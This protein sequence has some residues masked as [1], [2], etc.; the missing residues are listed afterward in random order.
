MRE[1]GRSD[2]ALSSLIFAP[3]VALD[4][5]QFASRPTVR[6]AMRIGPFRRWGI[7]PAGFSLFGTASE[8]RIRSGGPDG[9]SFILRP[10]SWRVLHPR[11][12]GTHWRHRAHLHREHRMDTSEARCRWLGVVASLILLAGCNRN[13][14]PFGTS[15]YPPNS[16][17]AAPPPANPYAAPPYGAAPYAAPP[18]AAAPGALPAVPALPPAGGAAAA[19]PASMQMPDWSNPGTM[20]QQQARATYHDPYADTTAAPEIVGGRP[21]EF[22]KPAAEPVRSR[23]FRNTRFPF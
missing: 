3:V 11:M 19:P 23:G 15:A 1:Q 6:R 21:R 8:F 2:A 4:D 14:S 9:P 16:Y 7:G 12:D 20:A 17:G 10:Q 13:P 22:S 18:A 5:T